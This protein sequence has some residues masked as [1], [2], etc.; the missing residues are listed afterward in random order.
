KSWLRIRRRAL[1]IHSSRT[2]FAG[3]LN[4]GVRPLP[5]NVRGPVS[6]LS[7]GAARHLAA[8]RDVLRLA[9]GVRQGVSATSP[10][11]LRTTGRPKASHAALVQ[12]HLSPVPSTAVG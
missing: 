8:L 1:T 7:H 10:W 4:S 6:Y 9:P 3:R 5:S 11:S 12:P 2:R